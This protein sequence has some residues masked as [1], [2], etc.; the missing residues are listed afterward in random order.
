MLP[1]EAL[2]I[3]NPQTGR[4]M[5][6]FVLPSF[7]MCKSTLQKTTQDKRKWYQNMQ[8]TILKKRARQPSGDVMVNC[9]QVNWCS[10]SPTFH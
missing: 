5:S 8:L 1:M 9:V 7:A 2:G 10:Q 3:P 4:I 6:S